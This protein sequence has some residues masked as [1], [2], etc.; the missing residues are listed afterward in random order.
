MAIEKVALQTIVHI[1]LDAAG[2][3]SHAWKVVHFVVR[4][5][6]KEISRGQSGQENIEPA[7]IAAALPAHADVVAQLG[8]KDAAHAEAQTKYAADVGALQAQVEAL[9][10]A[11]EALAGQ[12]AAALVAL[13]PKA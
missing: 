13:S 6:G 3:V 8:Q 1:A 7:D 5:D 2:A 4:E 12:V 9:T 10:A 11:E